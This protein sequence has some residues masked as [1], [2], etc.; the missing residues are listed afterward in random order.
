MTLPNPHLDACRRE[1]EAVKQICGADAPPSELVG[2]LAGSSYIYASS[3]I[4]R[5]RSGHP[6]LIAHRP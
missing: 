5:R 2:C 1:I 4:P 3:L 6:Y